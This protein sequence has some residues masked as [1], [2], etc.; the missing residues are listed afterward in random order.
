MARLAAETQWYE[1]RTGEVIVPEGEA[2]PGLYF[3]AYGYVKAVKY[4][5]AGR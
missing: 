2:Q 3:L 4:S 1:Y 5:A